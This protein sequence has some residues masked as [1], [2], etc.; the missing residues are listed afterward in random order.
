MT[1]EEIAAWLGVPAGRQLAPW[2]V[3]G[4]A[5]VPVPGFDDAAQVETFRTFLRAAAAA[6]VKP[7]ARGM[8][9]SYAP[10]TE[11]EQ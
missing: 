3:N 4:L 10:K 11:G 7:G 2:V 5:D 6:G 9:A 8:L 1:S